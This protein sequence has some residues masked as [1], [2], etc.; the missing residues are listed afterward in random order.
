MRL[1]RVHKALWR[2]FNI[3][4]QLRGTLALRTKGQ[5]VSVVGCGFL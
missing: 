2:I 4:K 1:K 5:V 3:E